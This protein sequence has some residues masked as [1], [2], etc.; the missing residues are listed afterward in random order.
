VLGKNEASIAT[1]VM[2]IGFTPCRH[3]FSMSFHLASSLYASRTGST[4]SPFDAEYLMYGYET[5]LIGQGLWVWA[6][7]VSLCTICDVSDVLMQSKIQRAKM[8]LLK[9]FDESNKT[10]REFLEGR[11]GVPSSWFAQ[12]LAYRSANCHDVVSFMDM[13]MEFDQ[14]AAL[15][16]MEEVYL[17]NL[18][19]STSDDIQPS[20]DLLQQFASAWPDSL[21]MTMYRYFLLDELVSNCMANPNDDGLRL[22]LE[23]ML[24]FTRS[25]LSLYQPSSTGSLLF[26]IGA[27]TKT[28]SA[29]VA[30]ALDHLES[31]RDQMHSGTLALSGKSWS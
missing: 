9:F 14:T 16:V 20:M 28:V 19:F 22:M 31:I 17:P 7:V 27:T 24:A 25:F 8:Y 30:A 1:A 13:A 4:I 15:R 2:P 11:V 3:D 10:A 6:V 23:E 26:P 18:F 29:M 21:V 12:A 5:Q